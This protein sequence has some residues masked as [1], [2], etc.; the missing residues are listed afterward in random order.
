MS[1]GVQSVRGMNDVLPADA[2]LWQ[3][4]DQAV[5]QV[6]AAYGYRQIRLP[7]LE[8][9][10]LFKRAV[11]EVTDIVEKEM[12]SFEDRGGDNV[13]L[14]PE[15]TAGCVRAGIENGLLYNQ[16]Q[17]LWY[18]GPMFRYERPQKGRYRQFHQYGVEAFGLTG[19][20]VDAEQIAMCARL[21]RLLGLS[22]LRLEINSLGTS[23]ERLAYREKLVAYFEANQDQLDADSQRRLNSNPMRILDSKNPDLAE[24]NANAPSLLEQLGDESQAHFDGLRARLDNL[25][26]EYSVNPR[27]VRGLDYYTRTVFEWLTSDLGAQ[28]AVCSG[29][30]FDGLVEML[31]GSATPAVGFAMGVERLVALMAQQSVALS[32][33]CPQV[34]I[35]HQGEPAQQAALILSEKLRDELPALRLS[36]HHGGGSFKSQFKRA[37]KSGAAYALVI[38]DEEAANDSAQ[39]KPL[40][41]Q[42]EQTTTPQN[43]L[44][45]HLRTLLDL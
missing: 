19:P 29:G 13:S 25:N 7:L 10:E 39:L 34:Y 35:V 4:L 30:R 3:T 15:G 21:W 27:L 43:K 5:G 41:T 37:D 8:R 26:I 24:L 9:T 45:A 14:R 28:D 11:G 40:R 16:T 18:G 2:A 44:G 1:A 33:D 17:K 42:E 32:D 12:Y 22:G 31:G 6:F 23:A 36:I 20:D 38:G